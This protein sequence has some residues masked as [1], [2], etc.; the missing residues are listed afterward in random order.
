MRGGRE[1]FGVTRGDPE[2][3]GAHPFFRPVAGE[4]AVINLVFDQRIED[5]SV[6]ALRQRQEVIVGLARKILDAER[7]LRQL[8]ENAADLAEERGRKIDVQ[9]KRLLV[10][11]L[12]AERVV[13]AERDRAQRF[14]LDAG[15]VEGTGPEFPEREIILAAH[16]RIA[17]G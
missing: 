1:E 13:E 5:K 2:G 8:V 4:P 9:P 11:V 15:G 3:E 7:D 12:D 6:P 16:V 17:L 14:R 10:Q